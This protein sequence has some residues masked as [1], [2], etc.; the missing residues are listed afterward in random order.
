MERN[1]SSMQII[2]PVLCKKCMAFYGSPNTQGLCS[3][4]HRETYPEKK[5]EIQKNNNQ[6]IASVQSEEENNSNKQKQDDK[7]T[8]WKCSKKIGIFGHSCKCDFIFCKKHR[9]P[10]THDCEFDFRKE[11]KE[12]LMKANPEI[13]SNKINRI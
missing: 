9:L 8:C 3:K 11:T 2:E 6:I 5:E 10:E 12:K 7:E 4:C 13:K 1:S